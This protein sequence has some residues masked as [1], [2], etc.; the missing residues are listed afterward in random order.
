MVA[1][2]DMKKRLIDLIERE[3]VHARAGRPARIIA[4]LNSL[5]D[6]EIIET[7]YEDSSAEVTIDLIVR[8][9]CCLQPKAPGLS[10]YI[11]VI[12]IVGRFLEHSR[13]YYFENGGQPEL[14]LCRPDR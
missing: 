1:P 9:I 3:R 14:S 5:V 12:S 13:I 10:E 11:R 2:F 6:Q 4:K 8:G 7:L